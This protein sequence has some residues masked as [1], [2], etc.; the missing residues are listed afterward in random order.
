VYA[1]LRRSL[2]TLAKRFREEWPTSAALYLPGGKVPA[3]GGLHKNPEIGAGLKKAADAEGRARKHGRAEA[4]GAAVDFW[5][6]GEV[7]RKIVEYMSA[8]EVRDASKRKH[9]GILT[10]DDFAAWKATLEEPVSATY[11]GLKVHKC[12][13][14]TQGPV[15]LQQLRLLEG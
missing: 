4:S 9:K 5:Y 14:W 1:G 2:T 3:V 11:R 7:A 13:P 15:F 6:R 8:T 12:G 10:T